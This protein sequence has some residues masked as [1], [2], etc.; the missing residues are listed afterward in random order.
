MTTTTADTTPPDP[1]RH[2]IDAVTALSFAAHDLHELQ[3]PGAKI[4]ALRQDCAEYADE[5]G[6]L[7]HH[8]RRLL[9]SD[10]LGGGSR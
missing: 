7:L 4:A 5:A 2:L 1:I 3:D 9:D 10:A 6:D 8:F